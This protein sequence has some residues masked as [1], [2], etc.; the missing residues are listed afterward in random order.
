MTVAC[1]SRWAA[2][3]RG[4]SRGDCARGSG[5][6]DACLL[7]S[8]D[9]SFPLLVRPLSLPHARNIMLTRNRSGEGRDDQSGQNLYENFAE[10][11][12]GKGTVLPESGV[13]F[14]ADVQN[15]ED[16]A[17]EEEAKDKEIKAE[18]VKDAL[19]KRLGSTDGT[20]SAPSEAQLGG[21]MGVGVGGS[22]M[23]GVPGSAASDGDRKRRASR[24]RKMEVFTADDDEDEDEVEQGQDGTG[25]DG[26]STPEGT[27]SMVSAERLQ[28]SV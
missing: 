24:S 14:A 11:T 1:I 12:S 28:S 13:N 27:Q 21:A 15:M 7:R 6:G 20:R 8:H 26:F 10:A 19:R 2:T 3:K 9:S 4:P 25:P 5:R 23:G 16:E 22:G 17:A 18:M